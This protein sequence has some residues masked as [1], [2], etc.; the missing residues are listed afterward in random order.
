[1][2]KGFFI[3][4]YSVIN[5]Q[6][7]AFLNERGDQQK[8]DK[9]WI[10]L[11]GSY[12]KERCRIRKDGDR[13]AVESGFED[14]PVIYVFWYGARAYARWA[15]K[16]LLAEEEWEKAARGIDGRVYP[17]GNEFDNKKCN[18]YE[19]KIGHT[20]PVKKYKEGRSPHGCHDMAGNVWEWTNSWYDEGEKKERNKGSSGAVRWAA[21]RGTPSVRTAT[22][23][24]RSIGSTTPGFVAP[25]HY[26]PLHFYSFTF[27]RRRR[28]KILT[29]KISSFL[30]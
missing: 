30:K 23:A 21:T 2:E 7:C 10:D 18:T 26:N 3:D 19:S 20:T 5:A 12:E 28:S 15:G 22:G 16:R 29:I 9:E 4:K 25:G 27:C 6:F 8:G 14:H 11:E 1:L 13:F 17:W 24:T